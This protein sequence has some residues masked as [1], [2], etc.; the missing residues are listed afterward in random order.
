FIY[1]IR[2][3]GLTVLNLR[4]I[5]E[6]IRVAA[7]FLARSEKILLVSRKQV[8]FECM[9]KFG[10]VIGAKVITGRFMPGTLTNVAYKDFFEA[11]VVFIVDP[12]VDYQALR[13]A[14]KA[15]VPV[16]AVCDTFNETRDIDL[17][18]PANNKGKK[19]L[20]TLFW[21]LARNILKERGEIKSD[22]EFKYKI[23]DFSKE[24]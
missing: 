1:K 10:E 21:L 7:K 5:D 15:K 11:D 14:V 22:S 24:E 8:A 6:R 23:S 18:I 4:K 16:V 9:K 19:A 13:E 3:D 2:E 17:I 12:L 20:A